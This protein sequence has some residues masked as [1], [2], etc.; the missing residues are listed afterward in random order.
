MRKLSLI[1]LL[2]V[3]SAWIGCKIPKTM[4]QPTVKSLPDQFPYSS[5]SDTALNLNW[6][7]WFV[8]PELNA[9][10]DTAIHNN[11]ELLSTYQEV[12]IAQSEVKEKKGEYLPFVGWKLGVG[13]EKRSENTL[14]GKLER[15]SD[16]KHGKENPDPLSDFMGGLN[17]N[18][19][20][21]IWKKLRNAKQAAQW[22]YLS[23]QEGL[24][25][26]KTQLVAEVATKYAQLKANYQ[27]LNVL[28]QNIQ[29]QTN[30][31]EIVKMQ[32]Q[33]AKANEL[34]VKKFEAA[35][36]KSLASK[37]EI[38]QE[39]TETENEIN[40]IVGTYSTSIAF[41]KTEL[42]NDLYNNTL[43]LP[44]QLLENRPDIKKAAYLLEAAKLDV[45]VAKANFY[46]SIGISSYF[47]LQSFNPSYIMKLPESL[48]FGL[49]GDL[50]A[51][52]V[53]K[54]AIKAKYNAANAIQ[55]QALYT[56]QQCLIDAYVDVANQ[57]AKIDNLNH[58]LKYKQNEAKSL[59]DAIDISNDLYKAAKA[60]YMEV[61][62]TQRDALETNLELIQLQQEKSIAQI[63]L[64]KALG[65]GWQ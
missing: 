44:V 16:I 48:I 61:L 20:L 47:G 51:P 52:L 50:V 45:K 8:N 1:S 59:A 13:T 24:N 36:N 65:G 3:S 42:L 17:F 11:L 23:T 58:N 56:Y 10:I 6:R 53:N 40:Q 31:L 41:C 5:N 28:E 46:P 39:I 33:A 12:V 29:I 54:N 43:G 49:A 19:E 30:V 14:L 15:T 37:Y 22:R 55:L 34:M 4:V 57:L 38:Q 63:K 32:K 64:Y 25:F 62:M 35:L 26:L 18:W 60:D 2:L 7:A 9:L 27:R 21:D